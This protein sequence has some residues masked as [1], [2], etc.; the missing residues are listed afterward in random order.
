MIDISDKE[1]SLFRHIIRTN[2]R[3][4]LF[5]FKRIKGRSDVN[6][7]TVVPSSV[8]LDVLIPV[9]E[10]DLDVLPYAIDGARKNI[11]LKT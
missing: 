10:K 1:T 7:K 5:W 2:K 6:L 11:R 4:L 3:N 8:K 9:A